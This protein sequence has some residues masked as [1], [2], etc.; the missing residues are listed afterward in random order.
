MYFLAFNY[1][2]YFDLFVIDPIK[3]S[4]YFCLFVDSV[5]VDSNNLGEDIS[6]CF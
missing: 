4:K 3:F 1:I 6:S 5:I 2:M